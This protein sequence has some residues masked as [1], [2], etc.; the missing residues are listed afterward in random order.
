MTWLKQAWAA[1]RRR[2]PRRWCRMVRPMAERQ[3]AAEERLTAA[4]DRRGPL[5]PVRPPPVRAGHLSV[6]R[7]DG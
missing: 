1:V 7:G 2:L 4:L 3:A 6:V 5:R